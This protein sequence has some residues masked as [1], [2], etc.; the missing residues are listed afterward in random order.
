MVVMKTV[1][2]MVCIGIYD[3]FLVPERFKSALKECFKSKDMK[4]V[5]FERN[6]RTQHLQLQVCM[7]MFSAFSRDNVLII[8]RIIT[9]ITH[10]QWSPLDAMPLCE[11]LR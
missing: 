8:F 6:Y 4:C 7:H 3:P 2:M 1:V 11:M 9:R 5:I 10:I